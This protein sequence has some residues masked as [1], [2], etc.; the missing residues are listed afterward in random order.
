MGLVAPIPNRLALALVEGILTLLI[1]DTSIAQ[2]LF[3]EVEPMSYRDAVQVAVERT[4][5]G[6]VET[7]WSAALVGR[8]FELGD[9][10]G[11]HP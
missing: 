10:E 1:A 7:R 5:L 8:S 11:G 6:A 2:R 9:T 4:A 3:P